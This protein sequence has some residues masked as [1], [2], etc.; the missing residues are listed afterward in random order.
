MS[1]NTYLADRSITSQTTGVF[2]DRKLGGLSG[3][4][5][6]DGTPTNN[7]LAI[8]NNIILL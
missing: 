6:Q 8:A 2:L 7:S 5:L 3:S 1:Y 4:D